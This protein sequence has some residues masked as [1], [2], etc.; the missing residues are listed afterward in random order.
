MKTAILIA[1]TL[2]HEGRSGGD[3]SRF[4]REL[5]GYRSH[6]HFGRYISR[7]AGFLDGI[8]NVRYTKGM[9][10]IRKEDQGRV[11]AYLKSRGATISK[12]EVLP[13]TEEQKQLKS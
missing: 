3:I 1:F 6:S 12:W 10:M 9:F 5:Y 8:K 7:K 2:S 11:V 13:G 4:Y